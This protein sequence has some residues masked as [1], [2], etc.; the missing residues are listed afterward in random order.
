MFQDMTG[1]IPDS[2]ARAQALDHATSMWV[3]GETH[4]TVLERAESF[5][6]FL[7]KRPSCTDLRLARPGTAG[8]N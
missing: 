3:E 1:G 4:E 8:A 7:T 6:Q 5:Y 2:V